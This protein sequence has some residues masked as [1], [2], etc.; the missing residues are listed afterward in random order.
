MHV[1][2]NYNQA[3]RISRDQLRIFLNVNTCMFMCLSAFI[4]L[5]AE[6]N[7]GRQ[8][9]LKGL[10]RTWFNIH[11][12]R[13]RLSQVTFLSI[14]CN[15]L[16][17]MCIFDRNAVL[18]CIWTVLTTLSVN[19]RKVSDDALC[20]LKERRWMRVT[21]FFFFMCPVPAGWLQ[22]LIYLLFLK[23]SC[24]FLVKKGN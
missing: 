18:H 10:N 24:I 19:E 6:Q 7:P 13:Y 9:L 23:L 8:N 4:G 20:C 5:S 22:V 14:D 2:V 3:W 21:F 15:V 11:R 17:I 1:T 12:E 16:V